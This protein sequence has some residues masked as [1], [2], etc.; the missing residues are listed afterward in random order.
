MDG[1]A[2]SPP[3]WWVAGSDNFSWEALDRRY[4]GSTSCQLLSAPS[5]LRAQVTSLAAFKGKGLRIADTNLVNSLGV[6][7]HSR[8]NHILDV[9]RQGYSEGE[10][11]WLELGEAGERGADA[12]VQQILIDAVKSG[13][14]DAA[15]VG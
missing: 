13:K 7:G 9:M 14:A 12:E 4:S 2:R 10:A 6:A 1:S 5:F 11:Q 3:A 15:F 8:L